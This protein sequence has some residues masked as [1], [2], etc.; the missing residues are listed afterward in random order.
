MGA[1]ITAIGTATPANRYD[2]ASLAQFM[3]EILDLSPSEQR[4]LK[5]LY[6]ATGIHHRHSVLDDYKKKKGS[7]SF[8]PNENDRFPC[9]QERMKIYREKALPLAISAVTDCL[10]SEHKFQDFTHLITVSCTGMYAPGLDVDLIKAL[11]LP[12]DIRRNSLNF[13]GCYAALNAIGISKDICDNQPD[14]KVLIVSIELCSLHLQQEKTEDNLLAHSLFGD[15]AAALVVSG[16]PNTEKP[17]LQ[18]LSSS[19]QLLMNGMNDMAWQIGNTGFQMALTTYVPR[20]IEGGIKALCHQMFAKNQLDMSAIDAFAIH[21]GGKKILE[22]IEK[23][24]GITKL[25]NQH[26]YETLKNYGNMSSPTVIFVLKQSWANMTDKPD[27]H[28]F[29]LAF[30]PG[31]TMESVLFRTA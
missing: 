31:L 3:C 14:A 7:F 27:R 16:N 9:T 26:A 5:V 4:E 1:F 6:R 21:P 2:Q 20:I 11:N 10:G 28:I 25:Q 18:V 29:S 8:Y 24:M 30:G 19:S 15:G 13:M 22:S 23:E 17:K 12:T